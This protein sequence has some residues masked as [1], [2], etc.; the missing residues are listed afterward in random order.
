MTKFTTALAVVLAAASVPFGKALC[1]PGEVALGGY[2]D[3]SLGVVS[4]ARPL[5]YHR[6]R[7]DSDHNVKIDRLWDLC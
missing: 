7:V 5:L 2:F 4:S 1:V 6:I 3:S